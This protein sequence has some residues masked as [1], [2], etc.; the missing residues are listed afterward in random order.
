MCTVIEPATASGTPYIQEECCWNRGDQYVPHLLGQ[1][2][3]DYGTKEFITHDVGSTPAVEGDAALV[4][5]W[6]FGDELEP[7]VDHLMRTCEQVTLI[8]NPASTSRLL[9]CRFPGCLVLPTTAFTASIAPIDLEICRPSFFVQFSSGCP[10]RCPYC[11]WQN[12]YQLYDPNEVASA[13]VQRLERAVG[14]PVFNLLGNELSGKQEWLRTLA[15]GIPAG[16]RFTSDLNIRNTTAQDVEIVKRAGMIRA[17]LGVEFLTD[18]MLRKLNKGHTVED[19]FQV[20]QRLQNEGIAYRFSLRSGVGETSEDMRELADNLQRFYAAGLA[21]KNIVCG[22][23]MFAWPGLPWEKTIGEDCVN[24]GSNLF[25][26]YVRR[27]T[28]ELKPIW[29]D[30]QQQVKG[31]GWT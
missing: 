3:A 12:R 11:V 9:L 8:A 14:D 30:L 29:Q 1:I 6:A 19:A 28:D 21:P 22:G 31:Y 15:S 25:P 23:P 17:C 16:S 10:W 4:F 26:R 2:C 24:V 13:I 18:K 7:F 20:M 5:S 27:M